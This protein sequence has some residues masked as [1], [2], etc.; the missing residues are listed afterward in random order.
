M[1][2]RNNVSSRFC[3]GQNAQ[4]LVLV[5]V[6]D[7]CILALISVSAQKESASHLVFMRYIKNGVPTQT[8]AQRRLLQKLAKSYAPN[9]QHLYRA[10]RASHGQNFEWPDKEICSSISPLLEQLGHWNFFANGTLQR[11]CSHKI[12]APELNKLR[13]TS[14]RA[15][16]QFINFYDHKQ[17]SKIL[18]NYRLDQSASCT[19]LSRISFHLSCRV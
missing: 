16:K 10:P 3:L 7:L 17:E 13:G 8:Q 1:S 4:C 12:S 15:F 14:S 6:S 9:F 2:R 5:L 18:R 11:T 19:R